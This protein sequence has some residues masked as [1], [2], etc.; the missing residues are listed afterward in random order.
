MPLSIRKRGK[1]FHIRGTVK[2][3]QKTREVKEF[4]TGLRQKQAAEEYLGRLT[5]EIQ[6]E[7]IHGRSGRARHITFKQIGMLYLERPEGLHPNDVWR[8]GELAEYLEEL[9]LPDLLSGWQDFKRVRCKDL[10]ASTVDRFRAT[11]QA[12]LNYGCKELEIQAP[13]IPSIQVSNKRIRWLTVTQQER[14]LAAYVDHVKPIALTLCFQGCR[15]QEALQLD[16]ADVDLIRE[17]MYFKRTKNG[18]PRS[19][20]MHQRVFAAV[21]RLHQSRGCPEEGH[22]F[23]NRL[24]KPYSDTR[25]YKLPGGNPLRAAHK[26]ALRRAGISDFR[27]HD[28]RHHFASQAVMKGVDIETIKRLGGWKSLRMLERY[29]AV[30]TDHMDAAMERLA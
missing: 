11:L 19:V 26:S 28:W 25:D 29:A 24:G 23:L 6:D 17:T 8:I 7:L 16:W 14:L 30:S 22:V 4:S 12:A 3:G 20:R 21:N 13:R 2:V 1:T 9:T 15:V 18:E 10:A 27:P 5:T